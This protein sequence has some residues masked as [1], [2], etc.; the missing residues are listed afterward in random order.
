MVSPTHMGSRC[1]FP[2][3]TWRPGRGGQGQPG[4]GVCSGADVGTETVKVKSSKVHGRVN[5]P[6]GPVA[7]TLHSQFQGLGF[8]PWSEN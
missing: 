2:G 7:K 5:I 8:D 4:K 3:D 6:D 1:E